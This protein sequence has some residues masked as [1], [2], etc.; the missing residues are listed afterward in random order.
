MT[1]SVLVSREIG[2]YGE[3][4]PWQL[5]ADYPVWGLRSKDLCQHVK[6]VDGQMCVPYA[7]TAFNEGGYAS[8]TLCA[9]CVREVLNTYLPQ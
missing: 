5:E 7:L 1:Y 9:E 8:T 2:E 6:D 4:I 3:A